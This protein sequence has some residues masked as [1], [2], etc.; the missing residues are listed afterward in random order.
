VDH[1]S[2]DRAARVIGR[3][4]FLAIGAGV[5]AAAIP[6]RAPAQ[7]PTRGGVLK[8]IGLEPA[9]FDVHATAAHQTQLV[10]S[11]VRRSL[12]SR[13]PSPSSAAAPS[14]LSATSRA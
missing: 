14:C 8:H 1:A 10:S 6:R 11:F 13:A 2:A 12:F 7:P 4:R 9:T 5:A 3:R